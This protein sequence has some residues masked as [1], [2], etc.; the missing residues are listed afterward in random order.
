MVQSSD[1]DPARNVAPG[2]RHDDGPLLEPRLVRLLA[3]MALR[4]L[5]RPGPTAATLL[6]STEPDAGEV[7]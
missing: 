4:V 2:H 1:T 6:G 7:L 3:R 5:A